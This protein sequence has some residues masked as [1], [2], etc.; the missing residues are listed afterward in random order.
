[1]GMEKHIVKFGKVEH[2]VQIDAARHELDLTE[3]KVNVYHDET[4]CTSDDCMERNGFA[5]AVPL[6]EIKDKD[7]RNQLVVKRM[8]QNADLK[9]QRLK[10]IEL[11]TEHAKARVEEHFLERLAHDKA[12]LEV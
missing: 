4:D 3:D 10:R 12:L 5:G 9:I 1:M 11:T 2:S 6:A 8:S 7:L